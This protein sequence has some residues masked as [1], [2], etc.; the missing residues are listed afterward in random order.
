MATPSAELHRLLEAVAYPVDKQQLLTALRDRGAA[1]ELLEALDAVP[2]Q[3]FG[4][5]IDVSRSFGGGS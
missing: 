2:D 4:S 3:V 1:A 5:A